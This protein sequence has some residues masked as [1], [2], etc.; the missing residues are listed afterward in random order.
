MEVGDHLD[1]GLIDAAGRLLRY[2]QGLPEPRPAYLNPNVVLGKIYGRCLRQLI[3]M[4]PTPRSYAIPQLSFE[5]A[6]VCVADLR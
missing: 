4:Q 2:N 3:G 1:D 5:I 6:W